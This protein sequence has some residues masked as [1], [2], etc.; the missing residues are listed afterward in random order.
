MVT[1][2]QQRGFI[3]KSAVDGSL[4][5]SPRLFELAH[6]QPRSRELL[7]QALPHMH[8][9]A[10]ELKHSC[11]I[12]VRNAA[13]ALVLAQVDGPELIGFVVRVGAR[14]PLTGCCSGQILLAFQEPWLQEE[15]L[16]E[17]DVDPGAPEGK[18]LHQRLKRIRREGYGRVSS[19]SVAGVTD[20]AAPISDQM[21]SAIA[22]LTVPYLRPR[23]GGMPLEEALILI[24][25]AALDISESLGGVEFTLG[26][27]EG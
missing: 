16:R 24:K 15:W 1:I 8:R 26:D 19:S 12:A 20:L 14:W 23:G 4:G 3:E 13:R 5:L 22:S 7:A 6:R 11:H 25:N 21:G 2:L 10:N 18:Q 9:L 27:S 17:C